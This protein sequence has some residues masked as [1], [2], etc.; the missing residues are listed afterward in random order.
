M[1]LMDKRDEDIDTSD[2]P[3]IR[4][5]PA[6]AVRGLFYRGATITLNEELRSYFADLSRRK[7]IPMND[8]VN[9]TLVKALAVAAVA[10]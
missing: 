6:G 1:A 9:E 7:G 2:M 8:L 10:K 3:E 4:E 5:L